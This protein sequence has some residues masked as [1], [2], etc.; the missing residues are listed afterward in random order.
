MKKRKLGKLLADVYPSVSK[1]GLYV[2]CDSSSGELY[3]IDDESLMDALIQESK[4]RNLFSALPFA[5][6]SL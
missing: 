3:T 2:Y 6:D 5:D 4:N 1:K